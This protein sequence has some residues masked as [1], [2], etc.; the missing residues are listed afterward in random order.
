MCFTNSKALFDLLCIM[1]AKV[2]VNEI[3]LARKR[4]GIGIFV[5]MLNTACENVGVLNTTMF[6]L[7]QCTFV[8]NQTYIMGDQFRF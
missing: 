3:I 7:A 2:N 6:L 4:V 8:R 5:H 1:L